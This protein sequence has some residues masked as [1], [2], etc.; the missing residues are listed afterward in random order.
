VTSKSSLAAAASTISSGD[1]EG[2]GYVDLVVA[3]SGITG[4]TL[5]G[6]SKDA[7]LATFRDYLAS[8]DTDAFNA[9]YAT[10]VT[11]VFNTVV[12]FLGLLDAG[13]K[14][15]GGKRKQAGQIIATSSIGAFNRVP[16]AGYA[17]GS[18]KTA[19][20]HMMKQFATSLVPYGIRSNVIAPGCESFFLL[21][22]NL[23]L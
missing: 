13:N 3:N 20:I 1:G 5:G 17:Y 9:T 12:A 16:L 4:P 6:L 18:S 2:Y 19:V 10:N 8:W 11:G 21:S 7:D 14:R 23:L 22:P 15:E